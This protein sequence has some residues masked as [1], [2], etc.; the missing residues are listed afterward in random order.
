[1]TFIEHLRRLL[2]KDTPNLNA[3]ISQSEHAHTLWM[4][5][6]INPSTPCYILDNLIEINKY[7]ASLENSYVYQLDKQAKED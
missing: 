3:F 2:D 4:E 5:M 6:F 1:M 7:I